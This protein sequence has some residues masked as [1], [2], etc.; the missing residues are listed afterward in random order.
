MT[1]NFSYD[2]EAIKKALVAP[3]KR[4]PDYAFESDEG[5]DKWFDKTFTEEIKM[6]D[7]EEYGEIEIECPEFENQYLIEYKA[8][9]DDAIAILKDTFEDL[10][11]NG[12]K[13]D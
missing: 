12:V 1:D 2:L 7:I 6:D 4:M 5:F 11:R 10:H 3:K 13:S 9:L 8:G